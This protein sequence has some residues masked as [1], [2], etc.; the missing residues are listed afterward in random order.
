MG[1]EI[2]ALHLV[3]LAFVLAILVFMYLRKDTVLI[4]I[5]GIF[6]VSAL[7]THSIIG[8]AQ[9]VFNAIFQAA[10]GMFVIPILIAVIYAMSK[11]MKETGADYIMVS[12]LRGL[13]GKPVVSFWFLG[14]IMFILSLF[15]WPTPAAGLVGAILVPVAVA[16]G[17]TPLAAA[18]PVALFGHGGALS[19]DWVLQGAPTILSKAAG[20]P[21][22]EILSTSAI[23][24]GG[25]LL[26]AGLTAFFMS[27]KE[28][29]SANLVMAAATSA[30]AEGMYSKVHSDEEPCGC[31]NDHGHKHSH[32][33]KGHSHGGKGTVAAAPEMS[34][35]AKYYAVLVPLALLADVIIMVNQKLIGGDATALLGGTVFVL[36][37]VMSL[38]EFKG[39]ALEKLT[40][41]LKCGFVFA[42][43]IFTPVFVIAAYFLLGSPEGAAAVFG[44]GAHGYLIEMGQYVATFGVAN[45]ALLAILQVVVGAMTGLDGAGFAQLPLVGSLAR[46]LA[47]AIGANPVPLAA[48][49]QMATIWTAGALAPWGFLAALAAFVGVNPVE[50]ARKNFMPTMAAFAVGIVIT[51][52]LM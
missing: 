21:I 15:F 12:P 40:E 34:A 46:S 30:G 43:E 32:G 45:K 17:M 35:Q 25:S 31:G 24:V 5:V 37:V 1:A 13:M 47:P 18:V 27:Y 42:I 36:M 3:Y 8:G 33:G 26:A 9:G 50:L 41:N 6:A 19:G 11:F 22:G 14:V 10:V 7:T 20:L 44:K 39:Q 38:A 23:I 51:V 4:T 52:F 29:R 49:G 28:M 48:L 16:A 2:T